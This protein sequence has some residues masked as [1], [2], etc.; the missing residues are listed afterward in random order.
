MMV[1]VPPTTNPQLCVEVQRDGHPSARH[2]YSN[3]AYIE[4]T[5][6]MYAFGGAPACEKGMGS[7]G[8]WLL[9][10]QTLAWERVETGKGGAPDG[11]RGFALAVYNP[12]N[13]RVYLDDSY[14]LWEYEALKKTYGLVNA[15][16]TLDDGMSGALDTDRLLLVAFG[17]GKARA[18]RTGKGGEDIL[19]GWGKR[20]QELR[21][22]EG[23]QNAA[24]PGLTYDPDIKRVVG[25][26]G[27]DSVYEFDP[28][29]KSCL[30]VSFPG[31][32]G[33][34]QER[35]TNGRFAYF[36]SLKAFVLVNDWQQDAYFLR[37]T[38]RP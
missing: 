28:D 3:L 15:D 25:W 18:I 33:K 6:K 7:S 19:Q 12:K 17:F 24:Y 16:A 1:L 10:L 35:G 20:S 8:T 26:A 31:G 29:T 2:T 32:P 13:S 22:C 34:Q 21:G 5:E 11:S 4:A 14:R 30:Q 27:G 37:L 38:P 9:D 36:P 23:L